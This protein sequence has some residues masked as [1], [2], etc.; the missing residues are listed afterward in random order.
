MKA[1]FGECNSVKLCL[2]HLIVVS[3]RND[4]SHISIWHVKVINE[5]SINLF[6]LIVSNYRIFVSHV[7]ARTLLVTISSNTSC[8]KQGD[9]MSLRSYTRPVCDGCVEENYCFNT[10]SYRYFARCM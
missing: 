10:S 1:C 6:I 4:G 9:A 2:V 5:K 8:N 7:R 3:Y